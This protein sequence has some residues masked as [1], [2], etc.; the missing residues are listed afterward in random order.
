MPFSLINPLICLVIVTFLN[1]VAE[2]KWAIS[3]CI[4]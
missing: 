3:V 2:L 1:V 4:I